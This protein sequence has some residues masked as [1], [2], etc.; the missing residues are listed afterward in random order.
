MN[1]ADLNTQNWQLSITGQGEV[2]TDLADIDQCIRVIVNT[3]RG[4]DPILPEFGVD[5]M[6]HLDKPVNRMVPG[7]VKDITDQVRRYELRAQLVGVTARFPDPQ[8]V[9]VSITWRYLEVNQTTVIN[10]AKLI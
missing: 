4:S 2:V 1:L 8:H 7:L 10:L 6:A 5:A 3:Q 9:E